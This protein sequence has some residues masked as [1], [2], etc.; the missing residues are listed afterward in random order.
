MF[1]YI[2]IL[3]LKK[4]LVWVFLGRGD[5]DKNNATGLKEGEV[6]E[7]STTVLSI[8]AMLALF[9][10]KYLPSIP[11]VIPEEEEWPLFSLD[12]CAVAC[13][14]PK[15]SLMTKTKK[16]AFKMRSSFSFVLLVCSRVC[17]QLSRS[18]LWA[19]ILPS[20]ISQ[21][22]QFI[23][24]MDTVLNCKWENVVSDCFSCFSDVCSSCVFWDD[25]VVTSVLVA[26]GLHRAL[27]VY[28]HRLSCKFSGL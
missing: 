20:A 2:F 11:V 5:R 15:Q 13:S 9:A 19:N 22:E 26:G 17:V 25:M 16:E 1:K 7:M 24:T 14:G 10:W 6:I 27:N 21:I 23:S 8:Y 18:N 4:R 28:H 12:R 3:G